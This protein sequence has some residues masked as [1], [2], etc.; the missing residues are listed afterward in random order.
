MDVFYVK[1]LIK[2]P[3]NVLIFI[4]IIAHKEELCILV[5]KWTLTCSWH[6]LQAY[7]NKIRPKFV[8]EAIGNNNWWFLF[9]FTNG[10]L[11]FRITTQM[12]TL[13]VS[14]TSKKE[15][16]SRANL[17]H[18]VV[19]STWNSKEFLRKQKKTLM[20]GIHR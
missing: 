17:N 6:L 4:S 2:L 16:F 15:S 1:I 9:F 8:Q 7:I 12:K 14:N 18:Q 10:F 13:N 19:G 20:S 3:N 11:L 5:S